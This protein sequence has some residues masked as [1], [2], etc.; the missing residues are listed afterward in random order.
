MK[1]K[2]WLECKPQAA[3]VKHKTARCINSSL[4]DRWL[5]FVA[6]PLHQNVASLKEQIGLTIRGGV[7]AFHLD[8]IST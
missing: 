6:N 4:L 8:F 7:C 3:A 2:F 5:N 1:I